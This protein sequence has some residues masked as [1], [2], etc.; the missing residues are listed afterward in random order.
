MNHFSAPRVLKALLTTFSTSALIA[1]P[2][3]SETLNTLPFDQVYHMMP[4]NSYEYRL[5]KNSSP[6]MG[7]LL[8]KGYR[9][10][11]IDIF[12]RPGS[13]NDF[14]SHE[15]P[16]SRNS[17]KA[18]SQNGS[19]NDCLQNIAQW[20]NENPIQEPV[21]LFLDLK[22]MPSWNLEEFISLEQTLKEQL[23]EA[24]LIQPQDLLS[25]TQQHTKQSLNLRHNIANSGWPN[26][27]DMLKL[28]RV[29]VFYTAGS[30]E[31]YQSIIESQ[32]SELAGFPCPNVKR[33]ADFNAKGKFSGM[34]SNSSNWV[35]C[36]NIQWENDAQASA[37]LKAARDNHQIN[38]I[39]EIE[40]ELDFDRLADLQKALSYGAQFINR[41]DFSQP[42][43][44]DGQVNKRGKLNR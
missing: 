29:I 39:W 37:F 24:G 3:Q 5:G 41:K 27:Q 22:D 31:F 43:D 35:V 6:G 13:S 30:P 26:S 44:F 8:D 34:N 9:S 10:L 18:N 33:A 23:A 19:L 25:W 28:G 32:N 4:H 14:V 40:A 21:S 12:N 42:D 38:H 15:G 7:L 16:G 36:G 1:C 17:C 20:L 2:V 11:E